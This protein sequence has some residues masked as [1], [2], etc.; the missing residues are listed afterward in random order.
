MGFINELNDIIRNDTKSF[1][2]EQEQ[3][4]IKTGFDSID[5]LNGQITIK[6][7][8]TKIPNVGID[9][10]KIV[11]IIGKSGSGKSTLALQMAANIIKK[12]DE[13]SMFV[14]DFEQSNTKDRIRNIT[15]MT[16]EYF[17]DHVT[18]KQT[19]IST[20]T[21]LRLVMQ[22]RK[23]KMEHEKQLLVDNAEGVYDEN[24]K[25][26]K[27]LPPTV[28]V[29]DSLAMMMPDSQLDEEEIQGQMNATS[30]AKANTQL[31]KRLVQPCQE[32]NIIMIFINHI[33]AKV[34]ITLVPTQAQLNYLGQD[35][36]LPKFWDFYE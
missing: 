18:L 30:M 5:Y 7:D 36:T 33:N 17:N 3:M 11:T 24:G 16:E 27:I 9:A 25:L 13:G 35:E 6:D 32:A 1:G 4:M 21:V 15:G 12:Y 34:Q 8:G 28:V 29:V 26:R 19:G 23:L 22:I 14:L 10:G 31:F 2:Y 20:N